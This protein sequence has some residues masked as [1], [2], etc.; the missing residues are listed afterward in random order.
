MRSRTTL[1]SVA[2]QPPSQPRGSARGGHG[3]GDGEQGPFHARLSEGPAPPQDADAGGMLSSLSPQVLLAHVKAA[4]DESSVARMERDAARMERDAVRT[5]MREELART[6]QVANRLRQDLAKATE[7]YGVAESLSATVSERISGMEQ[8][9][10]LQLGVVSSERQEVE[11]RYQLRVAKLEQQLGALREDSDATTAELERVG[12]AQK[13]QLLQTEMELR[14]KVARLTHALRLQKQAAEELESKRSHHQREAES[15]MEDVARLN[16]EL[17]AARTDMGVSKQ[18]LAAAREDVESA[19]CL[20]RTDAMD[21]DRNEQQLRARLIA[22]ERGQAS[23]ERK[24][25]TATGRAIKAEGALGDVL[26]DNEDVRIE[27]LDTQKHREASLALCEAYKQERDDLALSV[28]RLR[29]ELVGAKQRASEVEV[30]A[31]TERAAGLRELTALRKLANSA[32]GSLDAETQ[33]GAQLSS[34]LTETKGEAAR[35]AKTRAREFMEDSL[36]WSQKLAAAEATKEELRVQVAA[37]VSE[38][39]DLLI[40][41]K[42]AHDETAREKAGRLAADRAVENALNE[43]EHQVAAKNI[44]TLAATQ[45]MRQTC[46][47]AQAAADMSQAEVDRLL[48]VEV[49]L[50]A[51]RRELEARIEAVGA[52]LGTAREAS[53]KLERRL[54]EQVEESEL[55]KEDLRAEA[56][57]NS[58][59]LRRLLAEESR[60]KEEALYHLIMR[61]MDSAEA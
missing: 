61:Q 27:L 30:A 18:E 53:A 8:E 13:Q 35:Y 28:D 50:G 16:S 37:L 32:Q 55:A 42:A 36:Q 43:Q 57:G 58:A 49:E 34:A 38:N 31:E 10:R 41:A 60:V 51:R 40:D 7:R 15:R 46:A 6:A 52:E 45:E 21:S 48:V 23:S 5:S 12:E 9:H 19:R 3:R 44:E 54:V 29:K 1:P 2:P 24:A 33:R 25:E 4:T 56:R 17:G 59:D 26:R 39:D 11:G 47:R 14:S 20:E 22:A